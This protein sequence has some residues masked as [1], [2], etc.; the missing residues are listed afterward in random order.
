M[1]WIDVA[2][3]NETYLKY[4]VIF[5][6]RFLVVCP[7]LVYLARFQCNAF[8]IQFVWLQKKKFKVHRIRCSRES[9]AHTCIVQ[10][11]YLW[12]LLRKGNNELF[13]KIICSLRIPRHWIFSVKRM[14]CDTVNSFSYIKIDKCVA[15]IIATWLQFRA[16]N[17]FLCHIN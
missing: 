14:M 11:E 6:L 1:K 3:K 4:Y 5:F 7:M 2:A 15:S 17:W 10:F 13:E 8:V 9:R 16:L 12:F